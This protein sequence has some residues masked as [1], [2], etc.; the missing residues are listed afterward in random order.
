MHWRK[1]VVFPKIHRISWL[2]LA[3][4]LNIPLPQYWNSSASSQPNLAGSAK[5]SE[6]KTVLSS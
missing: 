1:L 2:Y 3:T 5:A 4:R 6:Q